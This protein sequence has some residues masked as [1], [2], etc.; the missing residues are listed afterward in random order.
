MIFS[1]QLNARSGSGPATPG[2]VPFRCKKHTPPPVAGSR[3][4]GE[5]VAG[6]LVAGG[7]V[8]GGWWL[9]W[10]GKGNWF[11]LYAESKCPISM[12]IAYFNVIMH[13]LCI[14]WWLISIEIAYF[15]AIIHELCI[16][17]L[18][19]FHGNHLF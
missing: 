8:A 15:N 11:R 10:L 17:E 1:F 12:E 7:W 3:G 14:N 9:G 5:G 19:D 18:A 16:N 13:D 6:W 4:Q 2:K